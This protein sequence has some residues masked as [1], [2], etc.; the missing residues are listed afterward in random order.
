[1]QCM[2]YLEHAERPKLPKQAMNTFSIFIHPDNRTEAVK[3]GFSF[4]GLLGGGLWLLWHRMWLLGALATVVGFGVY[5]LLP[6]PQGY[7]Y[8]IPYGHRFGVADIVNIG[9][10]IVVGFL[11]NEWRAS[12][13]VS[14]GFECVGAEQAATPDGAKAAYLRR[15]STPDGQRA[16]VR[17]EPS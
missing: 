1:M 7:V 12:T 3:Q 11:G 6:N 2:H 10:C 5:P 8:G 4:P 15:G 9:I 14:R 13:L 16:F 17:R